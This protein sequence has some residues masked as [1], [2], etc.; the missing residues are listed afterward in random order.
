[1]T[2]VGLVAGL[3]L[4]GCASAPVAPQSPPGSDLPQASLPVPTTEE[5]AFPPPAEPVPPAI[6]KAEAIRQ[7]QR[8]MPRGLRPLRAPG[9]APILVYDPEGDA[10][11]ECLAVAVPAAGLSPDELTRLSDPSRLFEEGAAPVGFQLVLFGGQGEN[12]E[13]LR[14]LPLGEHLVFEALRAGPLSRQAA[15]PLVVT[16]SFLTPD[17]RETELLAF[18]RP[19]GPPRYHRSLT[20]T[21]SASSYLED[22]DGD[23]VQDLVLSERAMEE[24]TGYETFLT[25]CRWNGSEFRQYRT[26]NVVRNLNAFLA[27]LRERIL[28]QRVSEVLARAILPQELERLRGRGLGPQ[29]ILVKTLGLDP[30]GLP[31][32]KELREIVFPPILENPFVS[33]DAI[34]SYFVLSFRIVDSTG[35]SY[36]GSTR[37]YLLRNPFGERQFGLA[38]ASI[39]SPEDRTV[40]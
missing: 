33:A 17:G 22:I 14:V 12:L 23:G 11:L 16:V 20:E 15:F 5:E 30:A 2:T 18:D 6:G 26:I 28:D 10:G 8:L 25:W 29:A 19:G 24:G 4:L 7:A 27:G 3:A 9:G 37:V 35:G 1:M 34:G 21:L 31:A 40:Q 32:L 36:I 39:D 13:L 38:A